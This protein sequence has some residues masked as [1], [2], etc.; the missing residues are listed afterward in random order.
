MTDVK[1]TNAMPNFEDVAAG[2]REH[3]FLISPSEI[4]GQL[5]GYI[6]AGENMNGVAWLDAAHMK[7]QQ[8]LFLQLCQTSFQKI[9][10]FSF[11]FELLLPDD[12]ADLPFRA[13]AL[14]EWCQGFLAGI[15]V[16]G[17]DEDDALSEDSSDALMHI[18]AISEIDYEN[19]MVDEK[20]ERSFFE[21]QEYIRL[22]V[23]MVYAN[24][25]GVGES[26]LDMMPDV[27]DTIH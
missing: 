12:D 4:H 9:N 15:G 11:D 2:L 7:N 24:I 6:C 3:N 25:A 8:A 5:C 21:V 14:G 13:Q 27:E 19:L 20:D 26:R 1:P 22:S 23:L 17:L 16:A 18:E 10:E